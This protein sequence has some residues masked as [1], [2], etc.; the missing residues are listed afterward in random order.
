MTA[1]TVD[2]SLLPTLSIYL[3]ETEQYEMTQLFPRE[4]TVCRAET[5]RGRSPI[6]PKTSDNAEYILRMEALNGGRHNTLQPQLH[7]NS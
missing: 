3:K 4:W 5:E 1:S 7:L 6:I 2:S